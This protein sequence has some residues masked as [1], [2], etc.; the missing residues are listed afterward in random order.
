MLSVII[1]LI[2][3]GVLR[4]MVY[5]VGKQ[6]YLNLGRACIPLMLFKLINYLLFLG[7]IQIAL[8]CYWYRLL[9]SINYNTL[10]NSSKQDHSPWHPTHKRVG[11]MQL[12]EKVNN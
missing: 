10:Q 5:P 1:V 6:S 4:E 9:S 7:F 2:G 3:S 12:R 11:C 8:L